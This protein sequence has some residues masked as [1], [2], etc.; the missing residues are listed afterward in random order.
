MPPE[1]SASNSM[2][3]RQLDSSLRPL[4]TQEL[5]LGAYELCKRARLLLQSIKKGDFADAA[6]L[7]ER[8]GLERDCFLKVPPGSLVPAAAWARFVKTWFGQRILRL[9]HQALSDQQTRLIDRWTARAKELAQADDSI[10]RAQAVECLD[11]AIEALL[12]HPLSHSHAL[13]LKLIA[14][15]SQRGNLLQSFGD[16]GHLE[17]ALVAF[18]TAIALASDDA[19]HTVHDEDPVALLLYTY[20]SLQTANISNNNTV[21]AREVPIKPRALKPSR[22]Q[23][24]QLADLALPPRS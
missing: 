10:S 18:D 24:N 13:R 8:E 17:E 1:T 12:A 6:A 15:Y 3:P 14:A 20:Q 4:T 22:R 2:M 11:C 19:A 23:E 9:P 5:L 7:C 16:T 21:S